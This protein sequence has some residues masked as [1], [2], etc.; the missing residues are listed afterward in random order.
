MLKTLNSDF[1]DWE[2]TLIILLYSTSGAHKH[3]IF[4]SYGLHW[5]ANSE[6]IQT[7]MR[8]GLGFEFQ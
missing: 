6:P 7:E 3:T 8:K 2:D 5:K 4:L 1:L